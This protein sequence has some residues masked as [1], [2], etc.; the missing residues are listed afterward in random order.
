MQRGDVRRIITLRYANRKERDAYRPSDFRA[1]AEA[2]QCH[3]GLIT[4]DDRTLGASATRGLIPPPAPRDEAR[5]RA[6]A[7]LLYPLSEAARAEWESG[8]PSI[9]RRQ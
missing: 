5:H 8:Q 6:S 2:P 7:D 9:V 1:W 4:I 3:A